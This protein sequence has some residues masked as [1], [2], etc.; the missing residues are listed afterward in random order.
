MKK[1]PYCAE[2]IQEEASVCRF[3]HRDMPIKQNQKRIRKKGCLGP[4]LII[5]AIIA[6]S[7]IFSTTNEN[8]EEPHKASPAINDPAPD[9]EKTTSRKVVPES[10][11]QS[12]KWKY[13]MRNDELRNKPIV[14]AFVDSENSANFDFPYHG[15]NRL[16]IAIRQNPEWGTDLIFRINRGQILCNSYSS[17][18][19]GNISFDGNIEQLTFLE[20]ADNSSETVFA[21]YPAALIRKIRAA[22]QVIVELP[23]YREGS[24]QFTFETAG[25]EWPPRS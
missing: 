4:F 12:A 5:F 23:F 6:A 18:C 17:P 11:K 19:K 13:T 8:T 16:T 3:C 24:Q 9:R 20:A 22:N 10:E 14:T 21:K 2:E 25:L 15:D 7:G 1:C